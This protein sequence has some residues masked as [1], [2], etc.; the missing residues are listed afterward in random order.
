MT[1]ERKP[2]L[3]AVMRQAGVEVGGGERRSNLMVRCPF[4]NDGGRPNMSVSPNSGLWH[5]FRCGRGGDVYDFQG[6]L[7]YGDAWNNRDRQQFKVVLQRLD[8]LEVPRVKIRP[9][10]PPKDLSSEIIHMLAL[11]SRVY[12]LALLGKAG[13]TARSYLEGRMIDMAAI[14]RFRLGYALPGALKAAMSGYPPRLRKA[15][16]VAGLYIRTDDRSPREL[17]A[18]RIVFPDID[19][20]G[21]V[22]HMVGRS[23]NVDAFI[24][25]LSL[26]GLPKTIWG[27]ADIKQSKPVVLTE[28]II[29]AV[30]LRQMGFQG[31]AVN[32]TGIASHLLPKLRQVR[33]LFILGQH[34]QAGV[35]AVRRWL[36]KLPNSG[37][38]EFHYR[39]GE[40]DLND[41]VDRMGLAHTRLCLDRELAAFQRTKPKRPHCG[42]GP[43]L[44]TGAK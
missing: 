17:L 40:K 32:G 28:S 24:R 33:R 43:R 20:R 18:E 25:Y 31:V 27:L 22:L 21:R 42:N 1:D 34:D 41:R 13:E 4:H 19:R 3:L 5:C 39:Q 44:D 23:L 10:A 11:A 35:D 6:H 36:E 15:A 26:S 37:E 29:D 16:E 8:R 2:D 30:N 9:P 38:L 7:V 14:R 12:H